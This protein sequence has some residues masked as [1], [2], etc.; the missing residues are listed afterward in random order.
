[1]K[2]LLITNLY[3]CK[4]DDQD[5]TIALHYYARQWAKEHQVHVI[6]LHAPNLLELSELRERELPSNFV[7]DRV[8]VS[9]RTMIRLPGGINIYP[10][11]QKE[12]IEQFDVLIGH[13]PVGASLGYHLSAKHKK[14]FIQGIHYTD[15]KRS[16]V[17]SGM[18]TKKYEKIIAGSQAISFRSPFLQRKFENQ[19]PQIVNKSFSMPGGVDSIWLETPSTRKFEFKDRPANILTV[20][21]LIERK[22]IDKVICSLTNIQSD[23]VYRIVGI[24]PEMESLSRVADENDVQSKVKFEGF[25]PNSEVRD[26]MD[27]SDIFVM[28]S[29]RETFGLVYLEAMAR[30]CIV[31]ATANEGVD[32]IVKDGKNGFLCE[33]KPESL[34]Q[35]FNKIK[36]MSSDQLKKISSRAKRTAKEYTYPAL[37]KTYLTQLKKFIK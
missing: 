37:A 24:G 8:N 34:T 23:W 28:I 36:R 33:P 31:V 25:L 9:N 11:I 29:E 4:E 32:G 35:V 15:Y 7:L 16:K 22:N 1:M 5:S 2:L 10:A 14:P 21:N 27:E 18:L 17:R 12:F 3:P 20:A 13:M 26:K 30:G 19:L 6:T